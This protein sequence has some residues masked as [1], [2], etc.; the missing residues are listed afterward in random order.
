M[1]PFSPLPNS[2]PF[3]SITCGSGRSLVSSQSVVSVK[4]VTVEF[5]RKIHR[6]HQYQMHSD[7]TI[8]VLRTLFLRR[9]V[10]IAGWL[11]LRRKNQ[12]RRTIVTYNLPH[13]SLMFH[14]MVPIVC[15]LSDYLSNSLIV[16][17]DRRFGAPRPTNTHE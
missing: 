15:L 12:R 1:L 11:F 6:S 14:S 13:P 9:A 16:D 17:L 8:L 7:Y 5:Y 10:K 4:A 3:P 2:L